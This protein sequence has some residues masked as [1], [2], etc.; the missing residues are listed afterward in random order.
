VTHPESV[1]Y[2]AVEEHPGAAPHAPLARQPAGLQDR[3]AVLER[4]LA[5]IDA[6]L[7][8]TDRHDRLFAWVGGHRMRLDPDDTVV[9]ALLREEGWFEPFE[10]LLVQRL[11]SPGDTVV[12]VGANIGYYTLQFARLVGATG[13]VVAFEPDPHNFALLEENVWQNGY[14][15]V[16]LVR[17]AVAARSGGVRLHLNAA[18]HGDHRIYASDPGRPAIDVEAVALDEYFADHAGLLDLVKIDVQGAE[19]GVFAG[20]RRLMAEQRVARVL[21]EFWPRGLKVAGGDGA[22]FLDDR[23]REGFEAS[24]VDEAARRVAPLDAAALLERLPV[25]PDIDWFF[26]NLLLEHPAALAAAARDGRPLGLRR[27]A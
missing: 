16:T 2:V 15:N 6:R 8:R 5:A 21:S 13:K 11:V 10:T 27:A 23:R 19:A 20:M 9:S 24:V 17:A 22:G 7:A 3:V 18:N 14:R 26:T 12:D 4:Q 1:K 25:E